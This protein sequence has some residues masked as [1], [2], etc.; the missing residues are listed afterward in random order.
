M[1]SWPPSTTVA[2]GVPC[3]HW[4]IYMFRTTRSPWPIVWIQ[5]LCIFLSFLPSVDSSLKCSHTAM[6]E[7]ILLGTA[8]DWQL[9]FITLFLSFKLCIF[10][11][12]NIF[13][14]RV[15]S[16]GHD[17]P[18]N[19]SLFR[20]KHLTWFVFS[21][22]FTFQAE[23]DHLFSNLCC[24]YSLSSGPKLHQDFPVRSDAGPK[25]CCHWLY[26]IHGHHDRWSL[27]IPGV[28]IGCWSHVSLLPLHLTVTLVQWQRDG[29][30]FPE[31]SWS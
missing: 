16:F 26:V 7:F 29:L 11:G 3:P 2:K 27:L 20:E 22:G 19:F 25:V 4:F 13:G 8:K 17:L 31:H 28:W 24:P 9:N 10:L 15:C 18:C 30:S 21:D 5:T 12:N 23:P 14:V 1:E 6:S